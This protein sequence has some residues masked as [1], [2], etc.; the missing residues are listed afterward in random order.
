MPISSGSLP[1]NYYLRC[2]FLICIGCCAFLQ[3]QLKSPVEDFIRITPNPNAPVQFDLPENFCQ[4]AA[5]IPEIKKAQ[6]QHLKEKEPYKLHIG[7]R[8]IIIIYGT[9]ETNTTREVIVDPSGHLTY[10]YT[11][12]IYAL[13]RTIDDVH[14]EIQKRVRDYYPHALIA[15][16]GKSFHG[17]NYTIMGEVN[18]PGT[19]PLNGRITVIDALAAAGGFPIRPYRFEFVDYAELTKAFLARNGEYIPVDFEK[20]IRHGDTSQ[21]VELEPNDYIYIPSIN[22]YDVYVLGEFFRPFVFSFLR[23]A[24]LMEVTAWAR[25]TRREAS[26]RCVII[27]GSLTCPVCISVDMNLIQKGCQPDFELMP[28]DIVYLPPMRFTSLK[29]VIRAAIRTFVGAVAL[30]AGQNLFIN[31]VPE[32]AGFNNNNFVNPG[33]ASSGGGGGGGTGGF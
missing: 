31:L 28:G 27:R 20:L 1:H 25:G 21:N 13:G 18:Q 8:L 14:A 23:R 30:Q 6:G 33:Q 2:F 9:E 24:T 15:L 4:C 10:L 29:D 16:S 26:S 11:G 7:D 17:H 22:T 5:S 3:A 19:K 32:A 12:Q